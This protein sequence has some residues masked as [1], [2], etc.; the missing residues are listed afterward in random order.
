MI[1]DGNLTPKQ[2]QLQPCLWLATEMLTE[3][4]TSFHVISSTSSPPIFH[5]KWSLDSVCFPE[6]LLNHFAYILY[7]GIHEILRRTV[8]AVFSKIK[9]CQKKDVMQKIHIFLSTNIKLLPKEIISKW[10]FS[11]ISVLFL[12]KFI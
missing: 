4:W 3:S 9:I 2:Q 12:R 10:F 5:V 1:H 6:K 7:M 8:K 11:C